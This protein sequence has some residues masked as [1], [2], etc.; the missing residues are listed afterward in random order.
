MPLIR[1]AGVDVYDTHPAVEQLM[2][3]LDVDRGIGADSPGI[4]D[5]VHLGFGIRSLLNPGEDGGL[6]KE[7]APQ[8][9]ALARACSCATPFGGY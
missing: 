7:E 2:H 1:L 3:L 6:Q 4:Q 9:R 8:E 5:L